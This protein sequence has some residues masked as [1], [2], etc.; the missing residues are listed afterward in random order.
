MMVSAY[1]A[2]G[3]IIAAVALAG[4]PLVQTSSSSTMPGGGPSAM[5][6]GQ[7]QS[8]GGGQLTVPDLVGKTPEEARAVVKAAG[9]SAEIESSRPVECVDAPREPGRINCQ[10]PEA[11][12]LVARYTMIQI[13]VYEAQRHDGR[14]IRDQLQSL[15]GMTPD[16]AKQQLKKWGHRGKVTVAVVS[17][18]GGG[19]S[20]DKDCGE[21]KVCDTS[22]AGMGLEDDLILYLNPKLT[23]APPP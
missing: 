23:I 6:N 18:T 11:G 14:I 16:Q 13:N 3:G 1:A 4:C 21:N 12:K 2:L 9:F 10:D 15:R 7:S 19:H 5:S 20:F 8:A 22:S 17:D